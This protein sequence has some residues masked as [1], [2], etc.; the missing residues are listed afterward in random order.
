MTDSTPDP[1]RLATVTAQLAMAGHEVHELANGGYIV[2][3]WCLTR[4]CPDFAALVAYA[5]QMTE[6][7]Q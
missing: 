4:H 6:P 5:R 7:Q 1:R 2:S 3:R